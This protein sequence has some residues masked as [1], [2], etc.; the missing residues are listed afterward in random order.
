MFLECLEEQFVIFGVRI[1]GVVNVVIRRV[2][3]GWRK[4]QAVLKINKISIKFQFKDSQSRKKF[5]TV[6]KMF[7]C[8][9]LVD[10][11]EGQKSSHSY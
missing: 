10:K 1:A 8:P 4:L 9:K 5:L 6:G 7:E 2:D 11:A 3:P